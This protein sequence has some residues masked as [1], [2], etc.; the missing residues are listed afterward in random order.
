MTYSLSTGGGI[1]LGL[2]SSTN[3][4]APDNSAA[5]DATVA[6]ST[7]MSPALLLLPSVLISLS[8]YLFSSA[9]LGML[10]SEAITEAI[11]E[12]P[13]MPPLGRETAG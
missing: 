6:E 2:R 9:P 10:S 1:S 4:A 7:S 12:I 5:A 3:T 11:T 13:P 8:V